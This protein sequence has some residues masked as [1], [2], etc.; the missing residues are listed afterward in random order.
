MTRIYTRAEWGARHRAGFG[1][2]SVGRLSR[3]LHHSAGASPGVG[4]TFAQDVAVVRALEDT[5][6]AR[7]GG[8][9]SYTF[10]IT[11]AGRRFEGTGVTRVGSHTG[12]H[13]TAGAGICLAGNFDTRAPSDAQ[14]AALVELLH[15]GVRAGWW[16]SPTLTGGHRDLSATACPGRHAYA[17]IP[18]INSG[19]IGGGGGAAV[20]PEPEPELPPEE[21]PSIM[22][23]AYIIALFWT[24]MRRHPSAADVDSRVVQM[25]NRVIDGATVA[26]ALAQQRHA[27]SQSPEAIGWTV[28]RAYQDGLGRQPDPAGKQTWVTAV[29]SGQVAND[30]LA[31]A[32]ELW[33]SA[34]GQHF[35][36]QPKEYRDARIAEARAAIPPYRTH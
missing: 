6:Q 33:K 16:T 29:A 10:V 21:D 14:V 15:H 4:A 5:G 24:H 36:A 28:T 13:N 35:L 2:R 17:L 18:A 8:G 34:E 22:N 32:N 12:N 23:A 20:A 7:F 27:I 3:W 25:A 11:E 31:V 1:V 9:I 30:V 19:Q 26:E